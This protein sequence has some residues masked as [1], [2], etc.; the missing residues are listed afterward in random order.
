MYCRAGR[1]QK[2]KTV[3]NLISAAELHARLGT[4]ELRIVDVRASLTDPD[5]GHRLY[6]QNHLPDAVFLSLE[7]D[8]SGTPE[9]HGG[10]HPLP[11]MFAFA[12]TLQ[13]NG[14]G[15]G[16]E[17]VV[18]DDSGGMFAARLWWLLRYA[19]FDGARVLDGGYSAWTAAALPVTQ[20]VPSTESRPLTLHLRP[21]L[22]ATMTEVLAKLN[23]DRVKFFDARAPDRYRGETEPL[24]KKAGHIPGAINKPFSGNLEDGLFKSPEA[25]RKRFIEAED[26]DEVILY[27]GSGVSAA[28]NALALSE[29]KIEGARLYIGSWSDWS[30]FEENPVATGDERSDE[31]NR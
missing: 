5:A 28:H 27:C 26:A 22:T 11:D 12:S 23:D 4:P 2:E 30:S 29:A 31:K 10:R 21:H 19:G 16:S 25:L 3:S 8:L 14:I 20:E 7:N 18:Y 15:D 24:D 1:R 9:T 17:V 13:T 6:L